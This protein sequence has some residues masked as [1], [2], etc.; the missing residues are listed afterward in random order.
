MTLGLP[1]KAELL[2]VGRFFDVYE[3]YIPT[4]EAKRI[5]DIAEDATGYAA[6]EKPALFKNQHSVETTSSPAAPPSSSPARAPSRADSKRGRE[7]LDSET[8]E[9]SSNLSRSIYS[10]VSGTSTRVDPEEGLQYLPVVL[11]IC[12]VKSMHS[13]WDADWLGA[14]ITDDECS[15]AARA[16]VSTETELYSGRLRRLQGTLVPRFLGT[17]TVKS[18]FDDLEPDSEV[19]AI[20]LERLGRQV[21]DDEWKGDAPYFDRRKLVLSRM[22]LFMLIHVQSSTG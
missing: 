18:G 13:R 14:P 3:A 16:A 9:R 20:V 6:T 2:A 8:S 19:Y 21:L 4:M 15:E 22:S 7:S 5:M 12:P 11:K 1:I 10:S 17:W